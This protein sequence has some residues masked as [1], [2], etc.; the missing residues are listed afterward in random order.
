MSLA[1]PVAASGLNKVP[2]AEKTLVCRTENPGLRRT[3]N[4]RLRK[5]DNAG[6]RRTENPGQRR[7]ESPGLRRPESPGLRRIESPGL[8][9]TES[10][11]IR[12]TENPGYLVPSFRV[13][14]VIDTQSKS[15]HSL[16]CFCC[17][18]DFCFPNSRLHISFNYISAQSSSSMRIGMSCER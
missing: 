5:T 6:I 14:S 9:S 4:P 2:S 3:K 8:R 11:G 16:L 10:P 13:T 1:S 18:Q 15:D 7:T 12:R 17:C